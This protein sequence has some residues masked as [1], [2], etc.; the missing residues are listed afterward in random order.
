ML[1]PRE[2]RHCMQAGNAWYLPVSGEFRGQI[3]EDKIRGEAPAGAV[4]PAQVGI[5]VCGQVGDY[6]PMRACVQAAL[7]K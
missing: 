1:P 5:F 2:H 4:L 6:E 7:V 3:K